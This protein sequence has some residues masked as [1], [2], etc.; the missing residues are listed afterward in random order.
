MRHVQGLK[1][2]QAFGRVKSFCAGEYARDTFTINC[3][4]GRSVLYITNFGIMVENSH[5]VILELDHASV[6]G[7]Q[8]SG[9][10]HLKVV[11]NED[12]I[13]HGFVFECTQPAQIESRYNVIQAEFFDLLKSIGFEFRQHQESEK[14]SNVV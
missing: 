4:Y 9:K 10:K 6:F 3:K 13:A 5:G 8:Q 11:W 12:G 1:C 2:S 7:M 14:S